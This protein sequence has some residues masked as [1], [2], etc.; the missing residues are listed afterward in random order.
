MDGLYLVNLAEPTMRVCRECPTH[1]DCAV[2]DT[3]LEVIRSVAEGA[4]EPLEGRKDFALRRRID[5]LGYAF[6]TGVRRCSLADHPDDAHCLIDEALE[7]LQS[8]LV[9]E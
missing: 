4:N 3:C 9:R 5:R 2:L 1:P 7:V 8:R 6:P